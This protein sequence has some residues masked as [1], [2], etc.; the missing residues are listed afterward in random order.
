MVDGTR[1]FFGG[2]T[3][4]AS[5]SQTVDLA[6]AGVSLD[7][8]DN[9][10][11]IVIGGGYQR[12]YDE[13]AA[14]DPSQIHLDF[15]DSAGQELSQ[16]DGPSNND[17]QW[18]LVRLAGAIPKS[19][20]QIRYTF[21]ATMYDSGWEE[22]NDGY[23]DAAF[24]WIDVD[25]DKDGAGPAT[26]DC[27]DKDASVGPAAPSACNEL[28]FN[29]GA[30]L[31]LQGWTG[32]PSFAVEKSD[33]AVEGFSYFVAGENQ[34]ATLEQEVDLLEH[35]YTT[36]ELDA[37]GLTAF[38]GGFQRSGYSS[39]CSFY[40]FGK[41]S[42]KV[43]DES[44]NLLLDAPGPLLSTTSLWQ[45]SLMAVPLPTSSRRLVYTFTASA[46]AVPTFNDARLD[47][48]SLWIR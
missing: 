39:E 40:T 31:G 37:G 27:D 46:C 20:R 10:S 35:G 33:E 19:T 17:E 13:F 45:P 34:V 24:L 43:L 5:I 9:G 25:R 28:L 12:S 6:Q 47:G 4:E 14:N 16:L 22:D 36:G 32:D 38:V 29:P 15:L 18:L 42:L 26:G 23:L 41:L 3:L 21:T 7:D 1:C 48:A 11:L 30:E 2:Q 8:I 44:G